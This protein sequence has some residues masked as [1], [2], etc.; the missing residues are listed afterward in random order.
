MTS[1]VL[2][3]GA[4]GRIGHVLAQAFA[5]AGWTVRAQAR[6]SLPAELAGRPGIELVTCD[7][8]DAA[9]LREAAR[10]VDVVVH[11]LNPVYTKWEGMVMPL[12]EAAIA[13]ARDSGALLMVPGNVYN[14]GRELPERLTLDTPER[15]D[16][17]KARLRIEVEARLAATPG[18][19]SV[20]I[21]AGDFFGG[22]QK[23]SWFDVSMASRI[24]SGKF[25]YPGEPE[26][27]HAWAYLP[28]LAQAFV[29]VAERRAEL[30]GHRRFHF[31][32][33]AVTGNDMRAAMERAVGRPLRV[34]SMPW[35]LMRLVAPV[36]PMMREVVTMSYL[37]KR[38]HRLDDSALRE[39]I[40]PVPHTPL[41]QALL[42]AWNALQPVS[43]SP[44]DLSASARA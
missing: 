35:W 11:A 9:A 3:L 16:L 21:R 44:A 32:G 31:A 13:A 10:G 38:P 4:A 26:L 14:F 43:S 34:A 12:A 24:K 18:L 36:V 6:K 27:M 7:A 42:G 25:V 37:W 41:D 33:H 2:I 39:F 19:D 1:T 28:D 22:S 23:G 5:D 40:G 8:L 15:G 30:H 29:R 20:V 17:P